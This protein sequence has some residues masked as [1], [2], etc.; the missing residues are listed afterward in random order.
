M[1]TLMSRF[2]ARRPAG[3]DGT[4]RKPA[5]RA[6]GPRVALR[7]GVKTHR[8]SLGSLSLPLVVALGAAGCGP[9]QQPAPGP[10]CTSGTICTWAG[11]GDPAF[12]G[13]G[14]DRREAMLY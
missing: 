8:L 5:G 12:Y 10:E 9:G 1:R 3:A 4:T 7:P 11:N 13:D 2:F 6:A 14:L